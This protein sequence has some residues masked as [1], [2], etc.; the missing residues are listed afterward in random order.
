MIVNSSNKK[1]TVVQNGGGK[2]ITVGVDMS[3]LGKMQ[4]FFRD[5]LY[6]FP[7]KAAMWET[8]CN[9]VDEQVKHK[10]HKSLVLL[11]AD[12]KVVVRDFAL[13]LCDE[14]VVNVFFKYLKTT[15]DGSNELTGGFGLGA[16]APSAYA[17]EWFVASTFQGVRTL[18]SCKI[19]DN[20]SKV[21]VVYKEESTTSSGIEVMIPLK[22]GDSG[23]A[24]KLLKDFAHITDKPDVY[25]VVASYADIAKHTNNLDEKL[26]DELLLADKPKWFV[27]KYGVGGCLCE[28]LKESLFDTG[29]E[30]IV[31]AGEL[32]MDS[33]KYDKA[34][35]LSFGHRVYDAGYNQVYLY[36]GDSLF[37]CTPDEKK[38]SD[39]APTITDLFSSRYGSSL[40]LTYERG[41]LTVLPDRDNIRADDRFYAYLRRKDKAVGAKLKSEAKAYV[42]KHMVGDDM[43]KYVDMWARAIK[44]NIGLSGSNPATHV[45]T[46]LVKISQAWVVDKWIELRMGNHPTLAACKV[47]SRNRNGGLTVSA[48]RE[49]NSFGEDRYNVF[50][51]VP[52]FVER[53]GKLKG[54]SLRSLYEAVYAC[55]CNG[56]AVYVFDTTLEDAFEKLG[57]PA[58]LA[59][60]ARKHYTL[61][62]DR[63]AE[64]VKNYERDREEEK[65]R[66]LHKAKKARPVLF[67]GSKSTAVRDLDDLK[68]TSGEGLVIVSKE[69]RDAGRHR[70]LIN[71]YGDR[72]PFGSALY[73]ELYGIKFRGC[74]SVGNKSDRD[75]LVAAGAVLFDKKDIQ[76]AVD[77]AIDSGAP[78]LWHRPGGFANR[79]PG[80]FRNVAGYMSQMWF[81][82]GAHGL[83]ASL[84]MI[85]GSRLG[86]EASL[87]LEDVRMSKSLGPML[88]A[89]DDVKLDSRAVYTYADECVMPVVEEELKRIADEDWFVKGYTEVQALPELVERTCLLDSLLRNLYNAG[90]R[91]ERD[92][93]VSGVSKVDAA[94]A[95]ATVK[96]YR[97]LLSLQKKVG[98]RVLKAVKACQSLSEWYAAN[99]KKTA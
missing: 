14:D 95:E 1:G 29:K 25:D 98:N 34:Y 94:L 39:A 97:L 38:M 53:V 93:A 15:K 13:G 84:S 6:K 62:E 47:V 65:N 85:F 40:L 66:G 49:V 68:E 50:S 77:K 12:D 69:D 54:R 48:P 41:E 31:L 75:K 90:S 2:A 32:I 55:V 37:M 60:S 30:R 86:I 70:R 19:T 87:G 36:D 76:R 35:M 16:N 63:V 33:R 57:L 44:C 28:W 51:E 73:A 3:N 52:V 64:E 21:S 8:I 81:K 5:A 56:R 61:D 92:A 26:V 20:E 43:A 74:V 11:T 24:L 80:A 45:H 91:E 17:D 9:A 71:S 46:G 96:K 23:E 99:G 4:Y 7:L 18:F 59:A 82:V 79:V 72:I 27:H 10:C 78:F 67:L 89:P 88:E 58:E 42:R 83:L 22:A